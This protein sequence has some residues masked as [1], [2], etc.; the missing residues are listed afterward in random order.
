MDNTGST[1]LAGRTAFVTGGSRGIGAVV[2]TALARHGAAVAVNYHRSPAAAKQ[3]VAT[4]EAEGGRALAVQGDAGDEPAV[5]AM[6]KEVREQLG[7]VDVLVC[8]AIGNSG[9]LVSVPPGT[10][11]L[12]QSE[13]FQDR[14]KTQI[15]VIMAACRA[16][17]PGMRAKGGGSIIFVGGAGSRAG[18]PIPMLAELLVAKAAMDMLG[19]L[20]AVELG[21]DKIRVNVI[22]PGPVP[23]DGNGL[24]DNPGR[25]ELLAGQ[26]PLGRIA[27]SSDVAGAVVAYASDLTAHI[28]GGYVVVDGGRQMV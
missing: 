3:V 10:S 6:L 7:V 12:D 13:L 23:T 14:T 16:A 20:L 27:E 25:L 17:V 1:L 28:T 4:I 11:L 18:T 15:A 5:A 24:A 21:K 8:N 26:T 19:R 9:K 2:A 22:A